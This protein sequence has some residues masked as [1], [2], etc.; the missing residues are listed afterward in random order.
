MHEGCVFQSETTVVGK[1][2]SSNIWEVV[3][4]TRFISSGGQSAPYYLRP[5]EVDT[6]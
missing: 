4:E 6:I 1:Q 2:V 3:L 5:Y